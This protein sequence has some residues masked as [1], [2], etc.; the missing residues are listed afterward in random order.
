MR[1]LAI[2]ASLTVFV[3]VT[4]ASAHKVV[5][6]AYVEGATV[7]GEVAFSNGDV[8]ANAKIDVFAP[9]GR[10]LHGVTADEE[11]FFVFEATERVD[12]V[13][14]VDLGAGHVAE[15]TVT[16]DE[17]P[18]TLPGASGLV[19]VARAETGEGTAA[20]AAVPIAASADRAE[21]EALIAKVVAKQIRPLQKQLLEYENKVRWHDVL[22][23]IGYII[24]LTGLAFYFL[25]RRRRGAEK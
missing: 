10:Q 6:A 14:R 1:A 21:L 3:F 25:A 11:G 9:D 5:A 20:S 22:G 13:I 7:E 16:A 23:G 15:L 2:G 17:L 4:P 8:A 18:A 12:H 24:G 19:G